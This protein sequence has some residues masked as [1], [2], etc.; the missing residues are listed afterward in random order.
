MPK[1]LGIE[2]SNARVDFETH[3]LDIDHAFEHVQPWSGAVQA[4]VITLRPLLADL[5]SVTRAGLPADP[6]KQATCLV[7]PQ[8]LDQLAADGPE[9][10]TLQQHHALATQPHAAVLRSE[11]HR[12][13]QLLSGGKAAAAELAGA[14]DDQALL[15]AKHL[16][17]KILTGRA[18]S[19]G[20]RS[21]S[22]GQST[23]GR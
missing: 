4:G 19:L 16:L 6:R 5:G 9:R 8:R 14:V 10:R 20:V 17:E 11:G 21:T 1:E 23:R 18:T 22:H 7:E 12:F 13:R 3:H 15:P 2:V